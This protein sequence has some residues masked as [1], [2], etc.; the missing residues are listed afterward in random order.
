MR[1]VREHSSG[2]RGSSGRSHV[3]SMV[4]SRWSDSAVWE[5][6]NR[7][8]ALPIGVGNGAVLRRPPRLPK[9]LPGEAEKALLS[10]VKATDLVG[11]NAPK[12]CIKLQVET[13]PNNRRNDRGIGAVIAPFSEG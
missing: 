5:A 12:M 3:V 9:A 8:S 2:A 11:L 6:G 1:A 7:E 13:H 4:F 10:G